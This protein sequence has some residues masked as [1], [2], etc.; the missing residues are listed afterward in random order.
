M[1]RPRYWV[2]PYSDTQVAVVDPV[3]LIVRMKDGRC[4]IDDSFR[5]ALGNTY[6]AGADAMLEALKKDLEGS[7]CIVW[8]TGA[9]GW[10]IK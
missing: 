5:K 1:W 3:T 10:G 7:D 9:V 6:E 2:S 8:K 4:Y